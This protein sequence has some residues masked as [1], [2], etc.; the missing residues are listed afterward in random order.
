MTAHTSFDVQPSTRFGVW[1][2]RQGPAFWTGLAG[3]LL[4]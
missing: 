1:I 4:L 3:V 2:R